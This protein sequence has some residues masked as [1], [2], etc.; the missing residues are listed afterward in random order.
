MQEFLQHKRKF[1][2]T[3]CRD[4][5][6]KLGLDPDL[7]NKTVLFGKDESGEKGSYRDSVRMNSLSTQDKPSYPKKSTGAAPHGMR[8]D[9]Q[10]MGLGK[11]ED[12]VI[13]ALRILGLGKEG[14]AT[15]SGIEGPE[16]RIGVGLHLLRAESGDGSD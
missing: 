6:T 7:F 8:S 13:N 16:D 11:D 5:V 15:V 14:I 9:N 10:R 12:Q 1:P 4:K 2:L 3:L